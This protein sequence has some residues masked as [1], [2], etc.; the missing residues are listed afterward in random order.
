MCFRD[1]QRSVQLFTSNFIYVIMNICYEILMLRMLPRTYSKLYLVC[2]LFAFIVGDIMIVVTT[3]NVLSDMYIKCRTLAITTNSKYKH[4]CDVLNNKYK[5]IS[6]LVNTFRELSL[7]IQCFAFMSTLYVII[8]YVIKRPIRFH[9]QILMALAIVQITCV[10]AFVILYVNFA[11]MYRS[12]CVNYMKTIKHSGVYR[13]RLVD[14][15]Y[16]KEK[17]LFDII[18]SSDKQAVLQAV[19]VYESFDDL[20]DFGVSNYDDVKSLTTC[21]LINVLRDCDLEICVL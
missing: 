16:A 8:C 5:F 12:T 2:W 9:V 18:A 7:Y 6:K 15:A 17:Y 21:Q 1:N 20:A 10:I 3:R 13:I 19:H 4:C 11:Y 14:L